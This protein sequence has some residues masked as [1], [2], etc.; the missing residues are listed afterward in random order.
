[1]QYKWGID[2]MLS[3]NELLFRYR[4]LMQKIENE[5]DFYLTEQNYIN[6]QYSIADIMLGLPKK[7][8]NNRSKLENL[9]RQIQ[10]L[11]YNCD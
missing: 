7:D 5:L 6:R 3:D 4:N 1:M 8:L 10:E 2:T 11:K 9:L